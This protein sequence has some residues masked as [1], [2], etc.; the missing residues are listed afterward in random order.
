MRGYLFQSDILEDPF[1]IDIVPDLETVTPHAIST[2]KHTPPPPHLARLY[3]RGRSEQIA[4]VNIT[5]PVEM[6]GGT[7]T[8]VSPK[9]ARIPEMHA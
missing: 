8:Y 7:W 6:K 2:H 5:A 4:C 9:I 3:T 1:G